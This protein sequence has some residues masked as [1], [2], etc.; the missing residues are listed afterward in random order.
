MKQ[1]AIIICDRVTKSF[2]SDY[3]LMTWLR[4]R[5]RLPRRF[6]L[7][8]VSLNIRSRS[9]FG[10]LGP[11]GAGKTTMLKLLATLS[12]PDRGGIVIDDIDASQS[13]DAVKARI[14]LCTSEER[15]FYYRLT[16]RQNLEF[17]GAL[18]G[19]RGAQRATRI[20]HVADLV[21][22]SGSLDRHFAGYSSGMRV[23]LALARA[24]LADPEILLL[25]EPTRGVDPIHADAVRKLM[26][27]ELV[28]RR[29]KTV[30]LTTNL[31]EEAWAVCDEVAILSQGRLVAQGAPSELNQRIG[32]RVRYAITFDRPSEQLVEQVRRLEGVLQAQLAGPSAE[33]MTVE[34]IAGGRTLTQVLSTVTHNGT[35]VLGVRPLDDGL[36]DLFRPPKTELPS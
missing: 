1:P 22:L 12:L 29:G 14:G 31:L 13:P 16:G 2:P 28:Q 17:F 27:D 15:S 7:E 11:N 18:A 35:T 33:T 25:D 9:L 4:H 34:L 30:V 23:R 20:A 21:D 5:G 10:L 32:G 24:L 8:D 6:A 19:L 36:L 3:G 26:R